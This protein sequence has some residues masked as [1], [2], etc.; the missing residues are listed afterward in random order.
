MKDIGW[1]D[2]ASDG[3]AAGTEGQSRQ[4]EAAEI[5][6]TGDKAAGYDI[7][8]RVHMKE[9]GWGEWV[10][11]GATAGTTG[12][13]RR[14]EAIEIRI[15]PKGGKAP[16]NTGYGTL[17][18]YEV[19]GQNYGWTQGEK[20]N[21]Q[22]AGT[23]GQ[24]LRLEA[25][26]VA[27]KNDYGQAIEGLGVTYRVH[28]KNIG[29]GGWVDNGVMAGTEGQGRQIEAAEIKL[30]GDKAADY[31]IYYRVHMKELGWGDWVTGG[32]TAGTT[33]QDRRIE[34]IEIIIVP[35]GGQAPTK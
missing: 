8:Y 23:T 33:G 9:L 10:T 18:A 14:I 15:V 24:G 17:A 2:W 34:A 35:K 7:Y 16:E 27:V 26:R 1:G 11:D 29:W 4:I 21:G 32:A 12:Q 22:L 31:D 5:K 3:A 28:M 25:L 30:T 6:L 19:H 13:D 20:Q